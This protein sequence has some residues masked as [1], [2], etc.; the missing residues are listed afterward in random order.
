MTTAVVTLVHRRHE[1]LRKQ[2]ASLHA[3][4]TPPDLYVV[5]AMDD[6]WPQQWQPPVEP[7]PHVIDVEPNPLGLP[8]A[9]ARNLGVECAIDAGA[10]VIIGLDVDCLA[11]RD[12]VGAYTQAVHARPQVVW[13]GPVTY[14][15]PSSAGDDDVG[16]LDALDAPHPAQ[17]APAPGQVFPVTP[18]ERFWSL[19][20]ALHHDLWRLIGGFCEEYV[21]YGAEDTDLGRQL[22][23]AGVQVLSTGDAR[24]YHQYHPTETP[25]LQHLPDLVRNAAIYARRWGS[26]PMEGWFRELAANGHVVERDGGWTMTPTGER[27]SSLLRRQSQHT[28]SASSDR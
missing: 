19:S 24:A 21:G 14:L 10:D 8:L 17:P 23:A 22:G 1:H 7:F 5:V 27:A 11:G 6:P 2:H 9:A 28:A 15:A 25:P 18:P 16:G 12:L 13:T 20:F 3:G 4:S 26:W